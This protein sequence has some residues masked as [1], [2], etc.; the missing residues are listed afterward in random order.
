MAT[1]GFI[2]EEV[3]NQ[4]YTDGIITADYYINH[5]SQ[6]MIDDYHRFLE[7]NDMFDSID[8]AEEYLSGEKGDDTVE[9]DGS[10]IDDDEELSTSSVSVFNEWAKNNIKLELLLGSDIA[11]IV[12]LWRYNN[13]TEASVFKCAEQCDLGVEEVRE[14]WNTIDF[15]IGS[16]GGVNFT[17]ANPTEANINTIIQD[18]VAQAFLT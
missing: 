16:M 12:T 1:N 4:Q 17:M 18:A 11:S 15:V 7:N 8:S 6:A 2:D 10:L 14:W 5:H 13:P 3:L 9:G